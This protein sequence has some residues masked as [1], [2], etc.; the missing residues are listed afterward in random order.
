[1]RKALCIAGGA[2]IGGAL[3]LVFYAL[4]NLFS[5]YLLLK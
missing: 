4:L 1:M 3:A 5:Q 2:S